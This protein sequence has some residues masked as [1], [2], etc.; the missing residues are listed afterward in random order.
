MRDDFVFETWHDVEIREIIDFY[1]ENLPVPR[2]LEDYE[3]RR[4]LSWFKELAVDFVQK[5]WRLAE[6][7]KEY[8]VQVNVVRARY[9][10]LVLYSDDYQVVT[11]ERN[12][13]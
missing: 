8:G 13:I 1:N 10:K 12:V 6:I 7:L 4:A 3:S 9:P 5:M 11:H 2:V